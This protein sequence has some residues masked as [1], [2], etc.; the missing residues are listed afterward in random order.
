MATALSIITR[1]MRLAKVMQKGETLDSDEAQDGLTSLNAMLDSWSIERLFVYYIV[2][3]TLTMVGGQQTYTMGTGGDLNTTRP[4][5]IENTCYLSYNGIDTP[6]E[7]IDEAA[8]AGITVKT[9]SS[10]MPFYLFP[11]MQYPLVRLNF[12]PAPTT[13]SAVANIKSWKQLAAFTDLTSTLSL[14]PGYERAITYGLSMEFGPEFGVS[15]APL[16]VA[17]AIKAMANIKRNNAPSPVMMSEVGY[18]SKR[19][20]SNIYIG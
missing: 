7:V 14:P 16:V 9:I 15:L 6:I 20:T 12:Y 17:T 11:D 4:S 10:P 1:A 13:S 18:L 5:K 19:N 3:E 8:W 2:S